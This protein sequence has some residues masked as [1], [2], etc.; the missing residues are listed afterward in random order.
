MAVSNGEP[1]RSHEQQR[2]IVAAEKKPVS[3][4]RYWECTVRPRKVSDRKT[5]TV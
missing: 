5:A 2:S 3:M 4:K 1:W